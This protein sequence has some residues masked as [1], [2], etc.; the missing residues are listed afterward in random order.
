VADFAVPEPTP[1]PL[2]TI[3]WL[4]WHT[5]SVPGRLPDIGLLGGMRTMASG[6]TS[7]YLAHHPV[8]TSAAEAVSQLR[9]GWQRLHGAIERAGDHQLQVTAAGY[10]H[11]AEPPRSGLCA[12]GPPG[13]ALAGGAG[14]PVPRLALAA[15]AAG[16][17]PAA[18]CG[19]DY[20]DPAHSAVIEKKI[21]WWAHALDGAADQLP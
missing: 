4:Y 21:R 20:P 13:P 6:W 1:V 14:E 3:A 11:A 19:L 16:I 15:L 12:A 10:T 17:I 8:F 2:T 5:G 18:C 9:D 7:P